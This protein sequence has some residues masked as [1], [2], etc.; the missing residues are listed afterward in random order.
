LNDCAPPFALL[1]AQCFQFAAKSVPEFLYFNRDLFNLDQERV[2]F[3]FG[4]IRWAVLPIL[5]WHGPELSSQPANFI[6]IPGVV[7]NTV[8]FFR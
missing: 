5:F 8:S 1:T 2:N 4:N 3:L 6:E 7:N